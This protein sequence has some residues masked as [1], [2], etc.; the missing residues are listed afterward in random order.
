L[1]LELR[2]VDGQRILEAVPGRPLI[3]QV[4]DFNAVL[5]ACFAE[6]AQRVLLYSENLTAGFFD[7]ST[8]E[9]GIILQKLRN[10]HVRLAVI[11]SPDLTLSRRFEE[12][13]VDERRGPYFRVFD[14]REPALAWLSE[15]E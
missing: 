13:L 14:E 1:D 12:L 7:L 15:E 5:E 3:A 4:D 6:D 10:Y 9:A 8:G 2:D 11:R